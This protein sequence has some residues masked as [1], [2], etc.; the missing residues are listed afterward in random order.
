MTGLLV[1]AVLAAS[2]P[3]PHRSGRRDRATNTWAAYNFDD[4]NG[5]RWADTW[6]ATL[7]QRTVD[8]DRPFLDFGVPFRF[9]DWDLEFIVWLN[10]AEKH[11]DFLSDDDFQGVP[12]G[13]RSRLDTTSSSFPA[14]RST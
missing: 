10:E 12:T 14:T 13:A 11:V 3:T 4:A 8:L 2:T 1:A 5:D 6:Y 7:K 9:H